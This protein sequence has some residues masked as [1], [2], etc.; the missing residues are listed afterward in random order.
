MKIGQKLKEK[1]KDRKKKANKK[2]ELLKREVATKAAHMASLGP[3]SIQSVQY[4]Q[5]EGR[6]FEAEK[7]LAVKEY[8]QYNL[9]YS[10]S[11]LDD[12]NILETKLSTKGDDFI[13]VAMASEDDIRE[14]YVRKAET[15]NEDITIRTYI[16]PLTSTKDSWH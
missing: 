3:I 5:T 9:R 1:N 10:K 15:K 13:N 4:F 6:S 2:K 14:L 7:V 16:I 11:E 8:L 12:L